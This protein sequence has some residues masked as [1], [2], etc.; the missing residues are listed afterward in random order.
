MTKTFKIV[1]SGWVAIYLRF[2]VPARI[3]GR[4]LADLSASAKRD[5]LGIAERAGIEVKI[6]EPVIDCNRNGMF[7]LVSIRPD[8]TTMPELFL[9][10][11]DEAAKL[12][13]AD[14]FTQSKEP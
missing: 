9:E 2:Y 14:G 6:A 4:D 3:T 11:A 10:Q 1:R 13:L 5:A 8:S 7:W 12:L